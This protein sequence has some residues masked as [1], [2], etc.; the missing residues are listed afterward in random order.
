MG[1]TELRFGAASSGRE[2]WERQL[3]VLRTA[4]LHLSHK[5]VVDQLDTNR[6]TLSDALSERNDRRWAGEWTP[7]VIRMLT[8]RGDATSLD[9]LRQWADA[10]LLG[11]P[12]EAMEPL[13]PSERAAMESIAKKSRRRA[14]EENKR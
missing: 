8:E 11:T 13:T 9:L 14:A 7:V 1:Q 5:D 3:E 10:A 6:S 12:Y 2:I 4:V